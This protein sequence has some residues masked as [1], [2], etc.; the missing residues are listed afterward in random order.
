MSGHK[1]DIFFSRDPNRSVLRTSYVFLHLAAN[2]NFFFM[3]IVNFVLAVMFLLFAFVQINDPDPVIWILIYGAMAVLSIMAIFKFY[4]TKFTIGLL[5]VYIL[6]SFVFIPGV[7]EWLKQDDK[8]MLFDDVAK[9]QYPYVEEAREFL[10]LFICI[11]VLIFFV[12][13]A[14]RK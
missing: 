8:S 12:I 7:L 10:G 5:V 6:Y 9:M 11:I 3:R 14:R 4:P 2:R 13:R 1:P